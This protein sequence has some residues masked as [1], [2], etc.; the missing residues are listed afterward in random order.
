MRF[1]SV[2]RF[3]P[4]LDA[5]QGPYKDHYCYWTALQLLIRAV[6]CGIATL[7]KNISLIIGAAVTSGLIGLYVFVGPF[8]SKIKNFQEL[9]FTINFQLLYI[10]TLSG[11]GATAVCQ[12]N[13]YHC[14]NTL[15]HH[16]H[17][18]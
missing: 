9:L 3:K 11:L 10:F 16:M 1:Q 15:H 2:N 8:K 6:F 18:H 13:G 14:C 17:G 4:L 5:Y 7:E 12:C